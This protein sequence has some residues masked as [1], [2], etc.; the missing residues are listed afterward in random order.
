MFCP[1]CKCEYVEGIAECADCH[2]P[3]VYELPPGPEETPR[4]SQLKDAHLVTFNT[5]PNQAEAEMAKS[6]LASHG[7]EAIL[8]SGDFG[9][10]PKVFKPTHGIHL[11]IREDD[12]N[13][14]EAIFKSAGLTKEERPYEK[15]WEDISPEGKERKSRFVRNVMILL[16]LELLVILI[17]VFL[18]N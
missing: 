7:I 17:L 14:A 9:H 3:L 10:L 4:E 16:L 1:Q 5:Y 11:F 15:R 12:L 18:R 13:E 2:V 6:F 8:S